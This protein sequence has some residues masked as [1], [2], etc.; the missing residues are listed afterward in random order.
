MPGVLYQVVQALSAELFRL[1]CA[2]LA[3][4]Q[5]ATPETV[6]SLLSACSRLGLYD[7]RMLSALLADARRS[8]PSYDGAQI[9]SLL[10]SLARLGVR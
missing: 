5:S 10:H 2:R 3:E 8:L 1:C 6:E 4:E 9:P 7:E